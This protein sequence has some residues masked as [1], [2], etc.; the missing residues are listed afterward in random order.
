[1]ENGANDNNLLLE[2][3][4][5]SKRFGGLSAVSGV[6]LTVNDGEIVGLIG[7][8][9]AGKT[10]L[11]NC[12]TGITIPTAGTIHFAGKDLVPPPMIN[13]V[14]QLKKM[15]TFFISF[16]VFWTLLVSG[17]YA[18]NA[19]FPLEFVIAM[20]CVGGFRVFLGAQLRRAVPWTRGVILLFGTL[21]AGMAVWWLLRLSQDFA[22]RMIYGSIPVEYLL[23]LF[24]IVMVSYPAFYFAILLRKDVKTLFGIFMRPDS[25]TKLGMARTFQ[26]IRLFSNLTVIDNVK[27][28]RHCRTR[29]NFFASVIRTPHMRR[30]E[31]EITEKAMEVLAFV[32]L[33]GK[34]EMTA[35]SLPYGEQRVLEIARA[36]ATEPRVLLLDEPAAGMNP[37]ETEALMRLIERIRDSGVAI[38]LIE[39]DMKVIM[40]ISDRIL[41]LD[42]G[43]KIAEGDPVEIRENPRV[44]E[45]Y[46]GLQYA[47]G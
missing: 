46:L 16:S 1:M 42:H 4:A 23:I 2:G 38:L 24:S 17:L 7:P 5:V 20:V 6:D 9:G 13:L 10:T 28:G 34:S 31:R 30:E 33:S 26:N 14:A 3:K 15:S 37:Y 8:N 36:L 22:G 11:F 35:S 25:V 18:G 12:L 27:L 43:Q 41:G 45:A 21:D 32:G 47:A 44:I 19:A 29:S 40:K 39:H